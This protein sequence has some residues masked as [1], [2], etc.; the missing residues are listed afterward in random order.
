[1]G[2]MWISH[3]SPENVDLTVEM[4]DLTMETVI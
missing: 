2:N 4:V 3:D 1:M